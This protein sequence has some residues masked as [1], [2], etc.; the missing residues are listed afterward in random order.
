MKLRKFIKEYGLIIV[1]A[2]LLAQAFTI[3]GLNILG[4]VG[5][6]PY[7][8]KLYKIPFKDVWKYSLT[9][10]LSFWLSLVYW[11][12][13]FHPLALPLVLFLL[14][15]YFLIFSF[16]TKFLIKIFPKLQF[17]IIP[18]LWTGMEYLISL[19]YLGFPWGNLAV[20][21]Y[22]FLSFIQISD[23]FGI[24]GVSFLLVLIN[25]LLLEIILQHKAK[26]IKA[27]KGFI[28]ILIILIASNILYG[29]FQMKRPLKQSSLQIGL[30]QGNVNPIYN[31]SQIK[32][33]VLSRIQYLTKS[34]MIH[35]KLDLVVLWET[36][37]MDYLKYHIQKEKIATN[38]QF[39]KAVMF[40]IQVLSMA[41]DNKTPFLIGIP[42]VKFLNSGS[43]EFYNSAIL[44]NEKG[45]IT[46]QYNKIHLVPFGE[47]FPFQN[48]FPFVAKMLDAVDAGN[49][50][51]GQQYTIF[52]LKD[53][54]FAVL[55][56]YEGIFGYLA[57][58]FILK[59]AD[60]FINITDDM[61]SFNPQAELQQRNLDIFR[62]V[63]NHVPF[64]RSGNSGATCL[65]SP[66]GKI[67]KSLPLF[68]AN[69][70]IVSPSFLENQKKTFYTKKGNWFP[71]L[72]LILILLLSATAGIIILKKRLTLYD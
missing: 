35:K 34:I 53:K 23:I 11:L 44:I 52:N 68:Q 5:L 24:W 37:I 9:F 45:K 36:A 55:I 22:S 2:I 16:V 61:W 13:I 6:I 57:R 30:I 66:F 20:T 27:V 3:K 67:K 54:K 48:I 38:P 72:I 8:Y 46:Q 70:L 19:G 14:S 63:E 47:W 62:A 64:I 29:T 50:T 21:Q 51:P 18:I 25:T 10:S 42:D 41:K 4:F 12:Y 49:Y 39:K 7:F 26:N 58:N 17:L 32:Y 65:I 69:S 40:D 43:Y 1:S 60:F 59:G 31:W 71:K 33:K 56:C 15:F 28:S